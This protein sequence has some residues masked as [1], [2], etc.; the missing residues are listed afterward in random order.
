MDKVKK[1]SKQYFFEDVSVCEM[2]HDDVTNHKIL[3][4]R[5]NQ[6]QGIF[7]RRKSGI[8]VSVLKCSKCNLIYPQPLPIPYN[9]QDHYGTPP[10]NYWSESYFNW[11][12]DY[13]SQE[14]KT[15]KSLINFQE[16]MKALDIGAGIGKCMISL[17]KAGFD[18]Y[19][20][21]P[22]K[23]FYDRALS[24]MGISVEKL[25]FGMVE[26]VEYD[27]D[28]F[29]FITFGA[30]LEHLYHP[31]ESIE[32]AFKWLR[33]GGIMQI[34]VPSSKHLVARLVNLYYR[35]IGTNY[36]TNISPMHSPFHLYEFDLNS[37]ELLGKRLGF[38]IV[39]SK[40]DVCEIMFIPKFLHPIFRKYMEWTK[41]GM[42]LTVYLKKVV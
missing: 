34:E 16:G 12:P 32:K 13:F 9:I 28:S 10:E 2:C 35:M 42:Q 21:E 18:V 5:L 20:F 25:K 3:G 11:H 4:Q 26:E 19:G 6:S 14:I 22:S 41:T 38:T 23:P 1:T 37:F 27:K 29:D 31:S 17:E 24:K 8:S 40:Y 33:P 30:V 7:P 39:K 36:V 15:V